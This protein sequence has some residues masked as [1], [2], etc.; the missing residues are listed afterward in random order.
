M[1]HFLGSSATS[2]KVIFPTLLEQQKGLGDQQ[3]NGFQLGHA[4]SSNEGI[5]D[6]CHCQE[7]IKIRHIFMMKLLFITTVLSFFALS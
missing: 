3:Q 5:F 1:D 7:L 6:S 2:W 4:K